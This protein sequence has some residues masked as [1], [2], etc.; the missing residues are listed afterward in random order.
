MIV[1]PPAHTK[2]EFLTSRGRP[3]GFTLLEILI[4]L[5]IFSFVSLI[6]ANALRNVIDTHAG[7][8]KKADRL[9]S[10]QKA[11]LVMSRDIEQVVNR[12][13]LN[14]QGKEEAAFFADKRHFAL[15]HTGVS[16]GTQASPR[17]SALQRVEYWWYDNALWRLTGNV[18][19]RAPQ[20]SL[21]ARSLLEGVEGVRVQYIDQEKHIYSYWPVE[22]LQNQ[23]LPHAIRI[24]IYLSQWGMISQFYVLPTQPNK[25][26][27]PGQP[28]P[29]PTS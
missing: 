22:G 11:L 27:T 23:P 1:T 5:F 15:T 2:K 17:I 18:L 3:F 28:P 7:T 19:D 9:R 12:P 13:I 10:L 20:S 14:A 25:K 24:N 26:P 29:P 21:H 16:T 6:L 4:A 8:E